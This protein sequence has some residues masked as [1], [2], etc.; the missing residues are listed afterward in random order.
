M[1]YFLRLMFRSCC[2][3]V[4]LWGLWGCGV[5][6]SANVPE[7]PSSDQWQTLTTEEIQL[8]IPPAYVGGDPELQ[9][10]E[11]QLA[12]TKM[13]F[14]DRTE[15]LAQNATKIDLLL[16]RTEGRDLKTINVVHEAR[17]E[18]L[19]LEA[20]LQQQ[21]SQLESGGVIIKEQGIDPDTNQGFLQVEGA[22]MHQT[23]FVYPSEENFWVITY[24]GGINNDHAASEIERSRQSFQVL[25]EMSE[26]L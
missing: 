20:Y 3:V 12:L 21:I 19:S 17:P 1:A 15:W 2:G 10:P 22:H 26:K 8:D 11:M 14:G 25:P 23:T 5:A 13:G 6:P 7:L 16:F 9:L 4:L 18:D 24:S